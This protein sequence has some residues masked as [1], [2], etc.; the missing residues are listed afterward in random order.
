M[1]GKPCFKREKTIQLLDNGADV[2][3]IYSK[4][5]EWNCAP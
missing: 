3:E 2:K 4:I 5:Q 1:K